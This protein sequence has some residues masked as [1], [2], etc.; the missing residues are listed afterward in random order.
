MKS[1]HSF[2]VTFFVRRN[3]EAFGR[4][5]IYVKIT[6]DGSRVFI[7]VK[8]TVEVAQWNQKAQKLRGNSPENILARDRM[9]QIVNDINLAY[10]ELRFQKEVVTAEKI[11]IKVEG[12]DQGKSL[13]DLIKY[14]FDQP[15]KLLAAGTLKNYYSTERFLSEFLKRKKLSDIQLSKIDFKFIT[16]FGVYLRTKSPDKGQRPCTNN[17]VMK[18][19]ER[20]QKLM[21]LALK[22][23]WI[24]R[25][26]F[27]HF[28]RKLVTKD[29]NV[30][31][32]DELA[33]I[34]QVDL[35]D[36]VQCVVRDMFVFSCYTGL[37]Y[38]EISSLASHHI[39]TDNEGGVWLV[40]Q[41]KK[42]LN[43]NER[44]FHVLVLPI[45]MSLIQKYKLSPDAINRETIF[46]CPSNQYTNRSLKVIAEKAGLGRQITF[47]VARHTFAT[48]VTLEKG[49]SIESVS[50]M[51]GH[52]SIRT[53]QIYSKVKQKKVA[54]EMK[55]LFMAQ[56][57]VIT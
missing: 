39:T 42:T 2:S 12:E 1:N 47:H 18:H 19:M 54:N 26:P 55:Y 41:R 35:P 40:M 53:T 5:P 24:L 13:R 30:L 50:H 22:F 16:D 34:R 28:T 3:R 38:S 43:T 51:L 45:A 17:T 48:T 52:S 57:V 9:R 10:D 32:D 33:S 4:A 23:G 49:I 46:P 7:P 8:Q 21:G 14:H 29:R 20:L 31:N 27:I 25:D 44:S 36:P 37:A 11:K 15:G 6:V 56:Q